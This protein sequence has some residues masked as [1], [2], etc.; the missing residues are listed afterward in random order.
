MRNHP[1]PLHNL[2]WNILLPHYARQ[3]HA[4]TPHTHYTTE[5]FSTVTLL[6][7]STHCLYFILTYYTLP[8]LHTI[9]LHFTMTS[10]NYAFPYHYNT[11]LYHHIA[12]L[13]PTLPEHYHNLTA[14]YRTSHS[15]YSTSH[16]PTITLIYHIVLLI[17]FQTHI[18][19]SYFTL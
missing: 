3:D 15:R 4:I 10:H 16:H 8:L 6:Y 17:S 1:L 18:D 7:E 13:Y 9:L 19:L 11:P 14:P 12:N 5:P 2:D